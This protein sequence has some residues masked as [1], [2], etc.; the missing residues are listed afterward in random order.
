[1]HFPTVGN[2]RGE[3]DF[4]FQVMAGLRRSPVFDAKGRFLTLYRRSRTA[5]CKHSTSPP[6]TP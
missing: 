4:Q 3:S 6:L 5:A 1:M 2:G